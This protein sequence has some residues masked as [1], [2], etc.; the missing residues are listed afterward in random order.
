MFTSFLSLSISLYPPPPSDLLLC[1]SLKLDWAFHRAHEDEWDSE[2]RHAA[3]VRWRRS[4]ADW[5]SNFKTTTTTERDGNT[6]MILMMI[7]VGR[8]SGMTMIDD[9]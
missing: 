4:M 1:F 3:Y 5:V 2:K 7:V 8:M 6:M 9:S